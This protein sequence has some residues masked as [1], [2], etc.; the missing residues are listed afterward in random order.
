M[1]DLASLLIV[2]G[3]VACSLHVVQEEKGYDSF[4]KLGSEG[5][6]SW[7]SSDTMLWLNNSKFSQPK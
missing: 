5:R 1:K 4:V 2:A 3:F 7:D 6:S